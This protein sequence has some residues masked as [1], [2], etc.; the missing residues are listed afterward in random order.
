MALDADGRAAADVSRRVAK[1][2]M[3]HW[4]GARRSWGQKWRQA[5]TEVAAI[6]R[7][8]PRDV[9]S[10]AE[11]AVPTGGAS[12][13]LSVVAPPST[14]VTLDG[15]RLG[16]LP[17]LVTKNASDPLRRIY[18]MAALTLSSLGRGGDSS[19]EYVDGRATMTAAGSSTPFFIGGSA[20]YYWDTS[21]RTVASSFL[22]P[23]VVRAWLVRALMDV[24][25]LESSNLIVTST[26]KPGG[27]YYVRDPETELRRSLPVNNGAM[28]SKPTSRLT[29][30]H[31]VTSSFI[32]NPSSPTPLP[33]SLF[34]RPSSPRHFQAFNYVSVFEATWRYVITTGDVGL[35]DERASDGRRFR[36]VFI[37]LATHWRSLPRT[38]HSPYLVSYG[39]D[40]DFFLEC[41]PCYLHAVAALQA[42]NAWMMR[43]AADVIERSAPPS[44]LASAE[45]ARAHDLRAA[46]ANVT[47]ALLKHSWA[48]DGAVR[49]R[50]MR[51]SYVSSSRRFLFAHHTPPTADPFTITRHQGHRSRRCVRQAANDD[52]ARSVESQAASISES[53]SSCGCGA[54][55][56]GS[57]NAAA[58]SADTAAGEGG[59]SDQ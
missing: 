43:T 33:P 4:N 7:R 56:S 16:W 1:R 10:A 23:G 20:Q 53:G 38:P 14:A 32:P 50:L 55:P 26:G 27:R 9:A 13:K 30:N 45:A 51:S 12:P 8:A 52:C 34:S 39:G 37:G 18:Y 21:L 22:E 28:T 36:E 46:A 48:P 58:A 54:L 5:F 42:A 49:A 47:A 35:L 19:S 41:V 29:L 2:F 25:A 24:S 11:L 6:T 57:A 3:T 44:G 40:K 17:T 15:A 59:V 31:P